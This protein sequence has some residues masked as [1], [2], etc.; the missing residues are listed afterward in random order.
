MSTPSP[1]APVVMVIR[2]AEKPP[3]SPPP[4]GVNT[5]GDHDDESLTV[6][7]WQRAGALAV[8][9]DPFAGALQARQ[10]VKPA[11]LYA[12]DPGKKDKK[13]QRPFETISP[14]AARLGL[15]IDTGFD[16]NDWQAMIAAALQQTVPV[17]ICWQ[18]QL[19]PSIAGGVPVVQGACIPP[20]WPETR[21][22]LVWVFTLQSG[23]A[24]YTFTQVPQNLLA[25]DE[26]TTI[27][28]PPPPAPPS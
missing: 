27:P 10:L 19:I 26:N 9:F 25:G 11:Y 2:H 4:H 20:Q 21:F 1:T 28:C 3:S 5:N 6:V 7:G 12:A 23:S 16:K 17:L 15:N 24:Q 13:S 18:H 14:L 8:L 22:D